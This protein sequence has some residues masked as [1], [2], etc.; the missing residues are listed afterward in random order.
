MSHRPPDKTA[1]DH[2]DTTERISSAAIIQLDPTFHGLDIE[3]VFADAE[4]RL[5]EATTSAE[6]TAILA[7]PLLKL[8]DSHTRFY[9]PERL[10][11]TDYGWTAIMIGDDPYVGWV[12]K[13]S[14]AESKGLARGDRILHWNALV[15]SRSSLWQINYVYRHVRPQQL[16]RLVV[17]K[18]DGSERVIDVESKVERRPAG[19]LEQL[20]R[21]TEDAYR[22]PIDY[23]KATGDI[24]VVAL[25]EFGDPKAIERFM[26]KARNYKGLVLD[27]RSNPRGLV[28]AIEMLVG[29]LFD[30]DVTIGT[31]TMRKSETKEIAHGRKDGYTGRLVVLVD[32]ESAS[33]SEVTARVVQLE[34]RG[35]IIGD[36]TAGAVMT[37][38][39]FSHT[40]GSEIGG[41]GSVAFYGTSITVGDLKMSDGVSLEKRGVTPDETLLPS[42]TDLA[43]HR[44][45]ALARAVTLLGGTLTPEQAGAFFK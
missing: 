21:E 16:Q 37:S 42:G 1:T 30:H 2:I 28:D 35:S 15:P 3:K 38:R 29:Y 44:D 24:L 17:R 22:T 23:E 5:R 6:A 34:K 8:D 43:A 4:A 10:A 14:D 39:F 36:R 18:P 25:S 13:T 7:D 12:R 26:R 20:I 9:P 41:V 33:A 11:K 31:E 40:L 45:P 32:S 27:L 19:D